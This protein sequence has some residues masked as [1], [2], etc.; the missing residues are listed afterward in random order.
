[1]LHRQEFNFQGSQDSL[2]IK[3]LTKFINVLNKVYQLMQQDKTALAFISKTNGLNGIPYCG[4][5]E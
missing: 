4:L 3:I 2:H 5:M 1:M